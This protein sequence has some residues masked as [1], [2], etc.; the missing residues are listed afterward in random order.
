MPREALTLPQAVETFLDDMANSANHWQVISEAMK[1]PLEFIMDA[2]PIETGQDE[3]PDRILADEAVIEAWE[4]LIDRVEHIAKPTGI[5]EIAVVQPTC[6]TEV[7][8]RDNC[9]QSTLWVR[10][11]EVEYS[12]TFAPEEAIS[13]ESFDEENIAITEY[14]RI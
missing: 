8:T 12:L 2:P 13:E 14:R 7:L 10:S 6:D 3:Q 1:S 4:T 9:V 11:P 5:R